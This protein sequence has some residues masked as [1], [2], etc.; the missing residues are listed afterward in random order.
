[1]A[2]SGS[3]ESHSNSHTVVLYP[4]EG[5]HLCDDAERMLID[6][7]LEPSLVDIDAQPELKNRFDTCVPVVEIDGKIRFRGRVN[8]MLLRR[9]LRNR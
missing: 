2:K 7:G 5:C 3:Q 6:H 4:R 8:A 9:L 1:M